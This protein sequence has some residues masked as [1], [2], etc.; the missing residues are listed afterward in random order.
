MS[1]AIFRFS[2]ERKETHYVFKHK[3]QV[4]KEHVYNP[5]Q[6]RRSVWP[7]FQLLADDSSFPFYTVETFT[8]KSDGGGGGGR[9]TDLFSSFHP[10][11]P[12]TPLPALRF[13]KSQDS[14][15]AGAQRR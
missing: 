9:E 7:S 6:L 14:W 11:S 4:R 10:S 3:I 1:Y 15:A 13:R 5:T 12:L 8:E 2:E